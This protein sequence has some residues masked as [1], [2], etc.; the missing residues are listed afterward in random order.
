MMEYA[1]VR[2][3][4]RIYTI[5][6]DILR[7]YK[8]S[9]ELLNERCYLANPTPQTSS[10]AYEALV[11]KFANKGVETIQIYRGY[12]PREKRRRLYSLGCILPCLRLRCW[13]HVNSSGCPRDHQQI[14][15]KGSQVTVEEWHLFVILAVGQSSCFYPSARA[16]KG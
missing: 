5:I 6:L 14:I 2:K 12:Y 8:V 15:C 9:H 13:V 7:L 1:L 4:T 10:I 16:Q 3:A 11:L